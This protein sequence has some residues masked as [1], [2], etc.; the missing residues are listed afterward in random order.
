MAGTTITQRRG[1][2][3][4]IFRRGPFSAYRELEELMERYWTDEGDGW[5]DG[6]G[7]KLLAPPLDMS[8]T[9]NAISLRMDLPG[10]TAKDIDIQVSGNQ[11]TIT[12]ERK[13]EKE[14]KNETFH[15][16]ERRSGKFSRSVLLPCEV[17]EDKIEATYQDGVLKVSLPKTPESAARHIKVKS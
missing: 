8:E 14:V 3:A 13:E 9:E 10:V 12:G 2:M 1:N 16:I 17:Q 5:G 15:R 6:W 11:L 7:G 4:P